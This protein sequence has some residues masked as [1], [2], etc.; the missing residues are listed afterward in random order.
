MNRWLGS[1]ALTLTLTLS[2]AAQVPPDKCLATMQAADGFQV[3]LF[4]SEPMLINPTSMDVDHK[5]RVWI[6]EAVNYRRVNF[7]RPILRPEGDRIVVLIDKDGDGKADESVT[8]YQGKEIIAPLG[9]CVLPYPDGKGQRVFV[10]QSPDIL[11]FEDKDGDLKAD[12][13]PKKLLTGFRGFDHDHGV[14]GINVGPD[15]KLYFT[16]GDAGVDGLQSSDGKG[17]KWKS[18]DTDC[19]A[20]TVW[21][22]DVDGTNLELIAHNFRNN[23]EACVDSF[24]E[25]WLSD[26]DDD[27]NQ[28]TRICFVMPGGNY[29]YNPRGP[30]QTHWHEEQPGIVHKTLRTGFGSPTGI[31]FY[32]G[33][34]LPPKYRGALLHCDAG[35]REVRAFFRKPKGA[36]YELEK[37]LLLTS[38][39]TWFRPS[40]VTVAPDGSIFVCDWYDPGVGGHGMGDWTRGRVFRLTPKG[41][42]GYAVPDVKLDTRAGVL[43]AL[44]SPCAAVRALALGHAATAAVETANTLVSVLNGVTPADDV[45]RARVVWALFRLQGARDV[46]SLVQV[47]AV[48]GVSTPER[49]LLGVRLRD[50]ANAPVFLHEKPTLRVEDEDSPAVRREWLLLMRKYPADQVREPFYHLAKQYDGQDHFYRAALNIA[51]GTDPARRDAILADFDKHFPE[52]NDTTADLVWELRPKSVLPRLGKLLTDPKLTGPQKARIVD[53]VAASDDPAAGQTM[54]DVLLSDAPDEVKARAL[55]QLRLFLPTKWKALQGSPG[56]AA[57]IDKLLAKPETTATGLQLIAASNSGTRVDQVAAVAADEK[58]APDTRKEAVRTL[59]K[60]KS[61]KSVEALTKL[62]TD[63][64]LLPTPLA[65]EVVNALAAQIT[66]QAKDE[67]SEKAL[68]ALQKLVTGRTVHVDLK[69][70]AVEALAG[71]RPGTDWLLAIKE[72][73]GLP[74]EVDADAGRLLRNSPFQAQRNKAMLLFPAPGKLDPK[75]LPTPAELAKRTGNADRGKQVWDASLTGATQCAKC[76]TVRGIG[77]QVGPDL[78]MIGKKASKENLFESILDPSKAIADQYVQHSVTTTA[79]V[80][81]SGLLVNDTPQAITLRDANGKDTT[82]A[83]ADID[84][85]VRK[86]KVSIM[87]QDVVAALTEDELIDLVAY[88]QT[89][90]TPALTPD[91]FRIAG[92]F[93]SP[94]GNAGLKTAF[95]PEKPFDPAARF[96]TKAG[97]V[98]WRSVRPDGKGY[99]DLAAFHGDAGNNSVSYLYTEIESPVDQDA[100][101]LLGTD[102]G[103]VLV[104]NGQEVFRTEATRAAAPGQDTVK[105]K[106]RKGKNTV[107]LKIANGNNPHG[108]YFTLLS[109]EETK[110]TK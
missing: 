84:G 46:E 110:V 38:T 45:L 32:E 99:F 72:R 30:G 21:R 18:N 20:G 36:G 34:L 13:P 100:E 31:T 2:A 41:H 61:V 73:G 97:E 17:R 33:K 1:L 10:C 65:G 3:E 71:T 50:Q 92:P 109:R 94:G 37:E 95:G 93:D 52:W 62:L 102:D 55:E 103:A 105:V 82:I 26:N 107:L 56:L 23:Y 91:S 74:K 42:K 51:C 104:V 88:L 75:K 48:N 90:Q 80:V 40:D 101:I 69:K 47:G 15:G 63:V 19:R 6:T 16:V 8:F 58:A 54:L 14:H 43:E 76:H 96:K 98:G 89:L 28:Q 4:A 5:G 49:R 64:D 35:P 53:I 44:G 57:V 11:V 29:G 83:K 81:V 60:L 87:P 27:G 39:D 78:S 66:N 106:L 86:L 77:G 79:G 9:V 70:Q 108:F 68:A 7:N 24:G 22:C 67:A 12:G 85:E 25:I 59:G